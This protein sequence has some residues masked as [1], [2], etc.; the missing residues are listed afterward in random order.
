MA[1]K[2]EIIDVYL[3]ATKAIL[4][5]EAPGLVIAMLKGSLEVTP[6]AMLSRSVFVFLLM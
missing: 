5:K 1:Q 2:N 4:E 6:M 3:Q